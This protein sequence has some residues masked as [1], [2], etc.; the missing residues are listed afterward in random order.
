MSGDSKPLFSMPHPKPPF[1]KRAWYWIYI[2]LIKW[3]RIH[4]RALE[5]YDKNRS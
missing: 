3:N 5:R 1:W 4:S 2:Y